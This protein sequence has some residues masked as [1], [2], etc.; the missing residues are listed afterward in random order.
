VYITGTEGRV[1]ACLAIMVT[2]MHHSVTYNVHCTPCSELRWVEL[3]VNQETAVDHGV[4]CPIALGSVCSV[5]THYMHLGQRATL[6]DRQDVNASLSLKRTFQ[7]LD[8]VA[9]T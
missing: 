6:S 7:F 9:W 2:R 8:S 4:V 1:I 5:G 3:H